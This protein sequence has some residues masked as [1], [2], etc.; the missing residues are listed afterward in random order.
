M[1]KSYALLPFFVA[2]VSFAIFLR[3]NV[4]EHLRPAPILTLIL[5]GICLGVGLINL[6]TLFSTKSKERRTNP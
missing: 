2:A 1:K 3:S 6:L 5:I 4:S